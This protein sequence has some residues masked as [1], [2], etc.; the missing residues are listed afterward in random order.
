VGEPER[1]KKKKE[2]KKKKKKRKRKARRR[3]VKDG[4]DDDATATRTA[5]CVPWFV[6]AGK[7]SQ[8]ARPALIHHFVVSTKVGN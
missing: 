5:A 8:P 6:A 1:G 2:S 3:K 7:F 4:D